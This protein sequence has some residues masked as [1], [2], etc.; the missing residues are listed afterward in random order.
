MLKIQ[1]WTQY[2]DQGGLKVLKKSPNR[3]IHK[4]RKIQHQNP[5]FGHHT[6]G[7]IKKKPAKKYISILGGM[8]LTKP[9][10]LVV[11]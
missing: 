2:Q 6:Q 11:H 8:K 7:E 3:V 9:S 1:T 10:I 4:V 5:E